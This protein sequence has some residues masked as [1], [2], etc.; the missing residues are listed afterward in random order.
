MTQPEDDSLREA[1]RTMARHDARRT[2]E[3]QALVARSAPRPTWHKVVPVASALAL[4]ASVLIGLR[5]SSPE[6]AMSAS[7]PPPAAVPAAP[8][9]T[10]EAAG[11]VAGAMA[12]VDAAPLDFL[13]TLPGASAWQ[14]VP[15]FPSGGAFPLPGRTR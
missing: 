12:V 3:F 11:A 8:A 7:A 15:S 14:G 2:P 6:R 10:T 5:M 9:A 13:L 1:F 4:A